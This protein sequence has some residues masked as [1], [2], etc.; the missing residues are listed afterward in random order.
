M[1]IQISFWI[2][3]R[4]LLI[5]MPYDDDDDDDHEGLIFMSAV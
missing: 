2:H 4:N 3:W 5:F 1:L